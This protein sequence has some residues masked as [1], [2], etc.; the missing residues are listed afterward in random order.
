MKCLAERHKANDRWGRGS[1]P[2]PTD[3]EALLPFTVLFPL[4][5]GDGGIARIL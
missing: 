2:G 5:L 1:N 4:Q 3:S